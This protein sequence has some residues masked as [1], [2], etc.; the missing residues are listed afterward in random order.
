MATKNIFTATEIFN[1]L[2]AEKDYWEDLPEGVEV[3][4]HQV[5]NLL[6]KKVIELLEENKQY[7][8]ATDDMHSNLSSIKKDLEEY[9]Y[10]DSPLIKF[11]KNL[12]KEKMVESEEERRLMRGYE[13]D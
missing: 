6:F 5:M 1:Y 10:N 4:D 2:R 9:K 11:Y 7:R 12:L 3:N 8:R 13:D